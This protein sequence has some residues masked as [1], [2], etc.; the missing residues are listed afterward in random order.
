MQLRDRDALNP[1]DRQALLAPAR[2][3]AGEIAGDVRDADGRGKRG[4]V[5]R[6]L[7]V[8]S[9]QHHGLLALHKPR[10]LGAESRPQRGDAH[11][12]RDVR[13][14]ELELR[15]HVHEQRSVV[16][17]LPDL[18]RG[19]RMHVQALDAQRAPVEGDD[20]LEVRRLRSQC[21]DR[22][23]DELVLIGDAEQL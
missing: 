16:A 21:C 15:A 8:P 19:E 6:V 4:G 17:R 2:H 14:V 23:T 3:A 13:L 5:T 1:L 12:A 11:R 10:E 22:A 20:V 18:A 7:V 9:D